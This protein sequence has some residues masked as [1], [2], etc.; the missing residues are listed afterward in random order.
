[1]GAIE[2]HPCNLGQYLAQNPIEIM[3]LYTIGMSC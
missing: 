2:G 3:G 1:M